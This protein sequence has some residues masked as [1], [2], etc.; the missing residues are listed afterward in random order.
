MCTCNFA[1]IFFA[2]LAS[3]RVAP[4]LAGSSSNTANLTAGGF[5]ADA[6]L[7]EIAS[8]FSIRVRI[9][10]FLVSSSAMEFFFLFNFPDHNMT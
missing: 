3:F 5:R 10:L 2:A 9:P 7:S 8:S 1:I 4:S 6:A